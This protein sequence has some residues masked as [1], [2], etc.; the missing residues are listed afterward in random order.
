VTPPL[1][2][3]SASAARCTTRPTSRIAKRA[4]RASRHG[5][6]VRGRAFERPCPGAAPAV[7]AGQRVAHVFVSVYRTSGHGR[8]RFLLAGGRLGAGR[9][10]AKPVEFRARG[11]GVWSLRRRVH[12]PR[13]SYLIRADAVD[14]LHRHQR[15]SSASVLRVR[16]R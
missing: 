9:S 1:P 4:V 5:F 8:C 10:C 13:G 15:H 14:G 3:F 12:I 2:P 7:S 6:F 16:V 11:T